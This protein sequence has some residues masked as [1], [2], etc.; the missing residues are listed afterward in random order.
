MCHKNFQDC[1]LILLKTT[2]V[3]E[4]VFSN[5]FYYNIMKI[6]EFTGIISVSHFY[7]SH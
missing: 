2:E 1:G 4:S 7:L 6:E 3:W 5:I